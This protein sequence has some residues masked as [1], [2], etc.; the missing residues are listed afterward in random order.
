MECWRVKII[1][2]MKETELRNAHR[3]ASCEN[4]TQNAWEEARKRNSPNTSPKW[5]Q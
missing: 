3:P 2:E 1:L 4:V 5:S